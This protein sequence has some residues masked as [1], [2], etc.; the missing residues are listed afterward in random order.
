MLGG[1]LD[2]AEKEADEKLKEQEQV[3][4]QDDISFFKQHASYAA[5]LE[6]IDD[7][8]LSV[9]KKH[10][11]PLTK[12]QK[13][14]LAKENRKPKDDASGEDLMDQAEAAPRKVQQEVASDKAADTNLPIRSKDGA[15]ELNEQMA[16][17][18]RLA[19]QEEEASG[20]VKA[21]SKYKR[22]AD[23]KIVDP[24]TNP[25]EE[26]E[27]E[28]EEED[29]EEEEE[30]EEESGEEDEGEEG[31]EAE[32]GDLADIEMEDEAGEEEASPL[33]PA[34]LEMQFRQKRNEIAKL[35]EAVLGDPEAVVMKSK[36]MSADEVSEL[37][38]LH[39]MGDD[40]DHKVQKLAL[41]SLLVVY[42]DILPGY[43]IR[44]PR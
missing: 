16:R 31:F 8:K 36:K 43:R 29:G 44:V 23:G 35:A 22:G 15:W 5:F 32:E 21:Q 28:E 11:V 1:A 17:K 24:I 19:K 14:K 6:N 39:K 41:L 9:V 42:Q 38:L 30:E 10:E 12:K 7:E 40:P 27:E 37:H 25:K 13:R 34:Q 2:E 18:N 4:D 3:I 20:G 26:G 33:T